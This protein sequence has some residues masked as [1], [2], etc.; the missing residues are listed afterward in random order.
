M[1]EGSTP[2]SSN[3]PNKPGDK[4]GLFDCL[5]TSK[6]FLSYFKST[7]PIEEIFFYFLIQK[8]FLSYFF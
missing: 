4:T 1:H 5:I 3:E 2:L 7:K 6:L 8:K